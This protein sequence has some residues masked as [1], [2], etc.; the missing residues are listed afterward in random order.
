[1]SASFFFISLYALYFSVGFL[2]FLFP[3]D[4]MMKQ[5]FVVSSYKEKMN[6]AQ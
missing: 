4:F 2:S 5:V 6:D 3:P 1:M